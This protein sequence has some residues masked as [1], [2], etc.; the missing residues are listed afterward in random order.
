MSRVLRVAIVFTLVVAIVAGSLLSTGCGESKKAAMVL[1]T[2]E[3]FQ[4]TKGATVDFDEATINSMAT[5]ESGVLYGTAKAI[6]HSVWAANQEAVANAMFPPPY[7]KGD[8][9]TTQY[10]MLASGDQSAVDA[11]IF[12][13]KLTTAEQDIVRN[14]VNGMFS[15]YD[16]ELAAAKPMTQNTAYGILYYSVS[17]AAGTAWA[18]DATAWM[19]ALNAKA[20]ADYSGKTFAQLTYAQRQTVMTAVFNNGAGTINPEYAFWRAMVQDGFRNGNASARW[21]DKRDAAVPAGQDVCHPQLHRE[22]RGRC[23]SLGELQRD[24]ASCGHRLRSLA[25]GIWPRN[26]RTESIPTTRTST[27]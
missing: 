13:T 14:A 4:F 17:A 27:T 9:T 5:A 20:A 23:R 1:P 21:P 22:A 11:T 24:R 19:T 3:L 8:G 10:I 12:A 18:T 6:Y 2:V 26:R 15:G 16:E 7:W 25:C